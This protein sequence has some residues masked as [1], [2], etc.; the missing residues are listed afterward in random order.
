MAGTLSPL[1]QAALALVAQGVPPYRAAIEAG[2]SP[3]TVYRAIARGRIKKR[4]L[5]IRAVT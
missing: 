5:K 1:T 4:P 2:I 3:S